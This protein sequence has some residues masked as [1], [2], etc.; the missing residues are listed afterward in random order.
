MSASTL[1]PETA[2]P[3]PLKPQAEARKPKNPPKPNNPKTPVRGISQVQQAL[4]DPEHSLRLQKTLRVLEAFEKKRSLE[5]L[6]S[7]GI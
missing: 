2:T 4:P 5:G 3:K 1:N 6:R 7:L